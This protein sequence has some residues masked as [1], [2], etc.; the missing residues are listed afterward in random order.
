MPGIEVRSAAHTDR[1]LVSSLLTSAQLRHLHLDWVLA[2]DLLEEQPFLL[3]LQ[4]DLPL[5][6]LAAPPDPAPMA[7][8][9]VFAVMREYKLNLLWDTL[10]SA[11]S[12][13]AESLGIDVFYSLVLQAWF[14]PLLVRSGF[15]QS[16]EVIFYEWGGS[17]GVLERD[18]T[19]LI[20]R[21]R[22]ADLPLV[23]AIDHDAFDPA[24][25]N[26]RSTLSTASN[27]STY[28]T[29]AEYEDQLVGYQIS[30]ASALGAHLAR[31]AVKKSF[32][33]RGIGR[34]LV[35]DMLKHITRRG[36]D[37]VTVNTQA[38]NLSSQKLYNTLGFQATGQRYPMYSWSVV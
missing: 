1:D 21:L 9:R 2:L 34:A 18:R 12:E 33:R 11:I 13:R 30:T 32:Q 16:N 37:R 24:W 29:V 3:A 27:L 26:S 23:E 28:A 22:H 20:R 38:D 19:I 31:L 17:A 15:R 36:F 7:W 35:V 4:N 14:E 8:I 10:W 5:A 25:Q 6:C